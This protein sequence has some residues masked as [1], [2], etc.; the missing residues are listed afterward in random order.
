MQVSAGSRLSRSFD[1]QI[2]F[3]TTYNGGDDCA[4]VGL[5]DYVYQGK[6]YDDDIQGDGL[7]SL[8][9]QFGFSPAKLRVVRMSLG[10]G[11][12]LESEVPFLIAGIGVRLGKRVQFVT[13][14]DILMFR[15]PY[16][17][18][19]DEYRDS[20]R[21]RRTQLDKGYERSISWLFAQRR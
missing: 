18:V 17:I 2:R 8:D 15:T 9:V 7:R 11:F 5:P 10:A 13:G 6:T 4:P 12:E 19:E 1:A 16:L 14:A 21:V 3:M 20:E